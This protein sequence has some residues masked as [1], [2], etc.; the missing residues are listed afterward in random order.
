MP[1]VGVYGT[2]LKQV[3]DTNQVA[4]LPTLEAPGEGAMGPKHSYEDSFADEHS[5]IHSV[6]VAVA[7]A[8]AQG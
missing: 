2:Q 8:S 5:A 4:V 1:G 6:Q 3:R 7:P